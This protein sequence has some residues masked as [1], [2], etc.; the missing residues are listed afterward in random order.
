[1]KFLLLFTAT[2]LIVDGAC[3]VNG[4][5][6]RMDK[7]EAIHRRMLKSKSKA[8]S[9][10]RKEKRKKQKTLRLKQC[11]ANSPVVLNNSSVLVASASDAITVTKKVHNDGS[12][13]YTIGGCGSHI[14]L[15]SGKRVAT[16]CTSGSVDESSPTSSVY[17]KFTMCKGTIGL[18]G[19]FPI[20]I[21][22]DE[23]GNDTFSMPTTSF[24]TTVVSATEL[25]KQDLGKHPTFHFPLFSIPQPV[26]DDD[27]RV[28]VFTRDRAL[29][30]V[31]ASSSAVITV[32]KTKIEASP[33]GVCYSLPEGFSS[34]KGCVGENTSI[35][36]GVSGNIHCS[37]KTNGQKTCVGAGISVSAGT[38]G[39][40][41]SAKTSSGTT[42]VQANQGFNVCCSAPDSISKN[43]ISEACGAAAEAKFGKGNT[44]DNEPNNEPTEDSDPYNV[45]DTSETDPSPSDGDGTDPVDDDDTLPTEPSEVEGAIGEDAPI[46]TDTATEAGGGEALG[47]FPWED[48]LAF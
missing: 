41:L 10:K 11:S 2:I 31:S 36:I 26:F 19:Q 13:G 25:F 33:K 1:M 18:V 48:L 37:Q 30:S 4:S 8:K 15:S 34:I 22:H 21:Q 35:G 27:D 7:T 23:D 17:M 20:K 12:A 38:N 24:K 3:A 42:P 32:D 16:M 28:S 39:I 45:Q 5:R 46:A 47:D 40:C 14:D 9:Q 29:A 43:A 6:I 44:K